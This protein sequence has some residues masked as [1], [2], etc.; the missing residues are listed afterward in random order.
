[1]EHMHRNVEGGTTGQNLVEI[2]PILEYVPSW[3]AKWKRDAIH[4]CKEDTKFFEELMATVQKSIVS[5]VAL[6]QAGRMVDRTM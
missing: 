2:F 6:A 1:M 4:Y 3:M 5:D